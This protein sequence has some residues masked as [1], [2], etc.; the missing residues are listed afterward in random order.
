MGAETEEFQHAAVQRSYNPCQSQ[1]EAGNEPLPL[2]L[3]L[4]TACSC[5]L[6]ATANGWVL[7]RT[8]I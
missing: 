4:Q 7:G 6:F 8:N 2:N 1:T 5:R 3:G